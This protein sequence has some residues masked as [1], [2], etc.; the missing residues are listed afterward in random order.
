MPS[1]EDLGAV[2]EHPRDVDLL[3][4]FARRDERH[5]VPLSGYR[6]HQAPLKLS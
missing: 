6:E 4:S 5:D 3:E 1:K 2:R